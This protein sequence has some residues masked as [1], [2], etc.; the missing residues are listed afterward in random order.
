[1]DG[2]NTRTWTATNMDGYQHGNAMDCMAL[3]IIGW[4]KDQNVEAATNMATL[5]TAWHYTLYT[6]EKSPLDCIEELIQ[7]GG[8]IENKSLFH[9]PPP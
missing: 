3:C 5:Y 8:C 1:M 6:S 9:T 4:C 7:R 2:T